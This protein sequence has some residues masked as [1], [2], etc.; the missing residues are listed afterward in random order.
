MFGVWGVVSFELV[1]ETVMLPPPPELRDISNDGR[2]ELEDELDNR[3]GEARRRSREL[4][5]ELGSESKSQ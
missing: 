4:C 2:D 1:E 5:G 3:E